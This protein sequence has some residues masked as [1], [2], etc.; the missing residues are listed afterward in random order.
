MQTNKPSDISNFCVAGI[1]YKKTDAATRGMFSISSEHYEGILQ[2]AAEQGIV[3]VF[4][5]STCN[6]TEIY[7]MAD[8]ASEL[9]SLLCS[10]A[11]GDA[12]TFTKTAYIKKGREAVEHLF[13]VGAGLDSQLLGD[14]EIVGQL[15]QAV[16]F[17]KERGGINC[18]MERLVNAALQSSKEIRT[19]TA[20][21][22]GTVS[23]SFAAV[24]YIKE[25]V[26]NYEHCNIVLVG[27]GKIGRN[28]CKNLVDY[29]GTRNIT[30]INRSEDKAIQLAK[31]LGLNHAPLDELSR[32]VRNADIVLVASSA[33]EPAILRSH[34]ENAGDK[35]IIDLSV[36][37]N[38][39]ASARELA[40]VTLV[41]VD[42][43]SK[44]KDATLKKREAEVPVA[45]KIIAKHQEQFMEWCRMRR[46]APVLNAIKGTLKKIAD[47]H[48]RELNNPQTR[49]PYI[50]A[51]Q[52]I[53]QVIN[54]VAG[55]MQSQN[56]PGCH[57]LQA[58]NEF[59]GPHR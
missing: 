21:S 26:I 2:A 54:G 28:T 16:K 6:R 34:L 30:L 39:E 9:V 51:E 42:E 22:G 37:N 58:I 8:N 25:H 14:Y 19:N 23:V 12:V 3:S 43:L 29:L 55:R 35:L 20:L 52:R 47:I 11:Q 48:N 24:Q 59:I 46:N 44:L 15:K 10:H 1:N 5:L 50:A 18:F 49:C 27:T 56:Q 36:P 31:E 40:N 57:Y 33:D 7:G 17:S 38:V 53:Q 41:N 13:S 32:Q 4:I 45:M